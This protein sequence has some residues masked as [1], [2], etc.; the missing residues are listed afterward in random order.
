VKIDE[1]L[2]QKILGQAFFRDK[3]VS[4]SMI[5]VINNGD[6]VW[7]VAHDILGQFIEGALGSWSMGKIEIAKLHI[8]AGLIRLMQIKHN[9]LAANPVRLL[10]GK[11]TCDFLHN[12]LNQRVISSRSRNF[13]DRFT[14]A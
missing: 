14:F 6:N 5:P 12:S 9:L 1:A 4:G 8:L 7:S 3:I 2:K 11:D 10:E 13:P